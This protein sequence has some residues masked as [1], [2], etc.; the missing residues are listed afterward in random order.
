MLKAVHLGFYTLEA[1]AKVG[2]ESETILEWWP[3]TYLFRKTAGANDMF[4][5]LFATSPA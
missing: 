3:N 5:G 2:A 1:F 4:H